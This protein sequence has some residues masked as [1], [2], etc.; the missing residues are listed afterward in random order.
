MID[1][2]KLKRQGGAPNG[3]VGISHTPTAPKR[4]PVRI[5]SSL[6]RFVAENYCAPCGHHRIA[7]D[8]DGCHGIGGRGEECECTGLRLKP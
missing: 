3:A 5:G 8:Q 7:H 4:T 1:P 6:D 2:D